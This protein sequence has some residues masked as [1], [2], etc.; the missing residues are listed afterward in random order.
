MGRLCS[1]CFKKVMLLVL[2]TADERRKVQK[3][4]KYERISVTARVTS[5]ETS[6]FDASPRVKKPCCMEGKSTIAEPA[7]RAASNEP[8]ENCIGS[9]ETALLRGQTCAIIIGVT[10]R[11]HQKSWAFDGFHQG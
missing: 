1:L 7:G 4:A 10:I 6:G 5:A 11:R 2:Y 9:N 8:P 3:R